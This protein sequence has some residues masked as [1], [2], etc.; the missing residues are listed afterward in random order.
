MKVDGLIRR[1]TITISFK[2][3]KIGILDEIAQEHVREEEAKQ[4]ARRSR[5]QVVTKRD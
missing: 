4:P 3:L 5:V 2:D 1:V